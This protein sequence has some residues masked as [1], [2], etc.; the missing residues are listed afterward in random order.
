[1]NQKSIRLLPENQTTII[2]LNLGIWFGTYTSK[3]LSPFLIPAC[4]AAPLSRT[5]LTCCRGAYSSP[6]ML[7]NWPPSLT[8][9]LTL[10]PKPVSVLLIVTTRG[11]FDTFMLSIRAPLLTTAS[12]SAIFWRDYRA[13]L[14]SLVFLPPPGRFGRTDLAYTAAATMPSLASIVTTELQ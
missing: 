3:I 14:R 10:N 2:N 11:P 5:A 6:L 4:S 12:P 8:W 1:M 7:L 9:P 13:R